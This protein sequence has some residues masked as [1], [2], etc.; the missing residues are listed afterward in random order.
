MVFFVDEN[1]IQR[2]ERELEM[3]PLAVATVACSG[4]LTPRKPREMGER[5][6]RYV[7]PQS[8]PHATTGGR[9]GCNMTT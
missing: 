7:L 5:P 2:T 3:G 1:V 6:R 9:R 8:V 4:L